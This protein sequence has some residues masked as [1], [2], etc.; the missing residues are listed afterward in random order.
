MGDQCVFQN[1]DMSFMSR[2]LAFLGIVF[3]A[4]VG[5]RLFQ[6][7]CR[8]LYHCFLGQMLGLNVD[9][10]KYR[11]KWAVVTGASDGIGRAYAEQ[12]AQNGL[13]VV[14]ISRTLSKLEEVASCIQQKSKVF[15]SFADFNELISSSI[16][17]YFDVVDLS[18]SAAG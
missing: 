10:K 17:R 3:L 18:R 1:P 9:F 7:V 13:N 11:G 16:N 2:L 6:S 4:M 5:L 15:N 8:G 12:L 14:L